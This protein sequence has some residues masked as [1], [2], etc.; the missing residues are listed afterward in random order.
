MQQATA[1]TGT[2]N[3]LFIPFVFILIIFFSLSS[4]G[5]TNEYTGA[6]TLSSSLSCTIPTSGNPAYTLDNATAS[7]GIPAGCSVGTHYDAW[8]S[9]VAASSTQTVTIGHFGSNVTNPEVQIFSGTAPAN[10][11]S[12]ACGATTATATTLSIG[13]T[14]FIRVS[15][16]G[17][18]P[19]GNGQDPKFDICLTNPPPPPSNDDCVGATTLTSATTCN[20]VAGT[21]V[22]VTATTGLQ[23]GCETA[24]THYDAWYKFVASNI[25][26]IVTI[27]GRGSN[28]TN[29]EVQLYSGTCA[30]L[31]SI[32]CG[33]TTLSSSALSIGATYY[34]RVSNIGSSLTTNGG[35]N[36]C[37]TTSNTASIK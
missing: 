30:G 34:V 33:T 36:I 6:P 28:F 35:F 12:Q 8:F 19:S 11:V 26:H 18:D 10:F 23:A 32:A 17:A 16:V 2:T 1:R 20:D 27:S 9:F 37:V 25:T 24:G 13:V 3:F 15:N 7:A 4:S 31:T 14:Y 5:Q 29:P 21:I 22:N